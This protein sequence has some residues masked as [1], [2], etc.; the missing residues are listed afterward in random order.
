MAYDPDCDPDSV[1]ESGA[2]VA[3]G[4]GTFRLAF[5]GGSLANLSMRSLFIALAF[6]SV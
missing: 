2:D 5:S 6:I 3:F 1:K 4:G